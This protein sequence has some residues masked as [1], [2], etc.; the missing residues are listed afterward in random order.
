MRA[1]RDSRFRSTHESASATHARGH[2]GTD[3]TPVADR[4]PFS[5]DLLV[6]SYDHRQAYD[7]DVEVRHEDGALA[8]HERYYLQ[9]GA[10]VSETNRLPGGC[11][12]VRVTL[13][14]RQERVLLSRID[15]APEHTAVVEVGNG[16]LSLTDGLL[17]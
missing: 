11:Y 5:E 3:A 12:Q 10:T 6:R 4:V 13:D 14:N 17:R 7:V 15:D 9:P 2:G 1:N 16:A 8:F